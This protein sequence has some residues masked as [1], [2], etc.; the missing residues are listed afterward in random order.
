MNNIQEL[1]MT[2]SIQDTSPRIHPWRHQKPVSDETCPP[3][4]SV[5]SMLQF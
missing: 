1:G 3:N 2:E 5:G 4:L